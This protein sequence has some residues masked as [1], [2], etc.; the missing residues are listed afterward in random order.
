M[1]R[2]YHF[3]GPKLRDSRELPPDGEWLIE[4]LPLE[5]CQKG[6]HY[7]EHPFDALI[8]APG[9]TL[10][11][12][13]V[14][15]KIL[16]QSDKGCAEKRR[17]VARIDAK[18]L[19]LKFARDVASDVLHLW[20]APQVVKDFLA[21]GKN[22]N[23]AT[24]AAYAAYAAAAYAANAANAAANEA[25][26][27]AAATAAANAAAT[28]AAANANA[29]YAYAAATYAANAAANEAYAKHKYRGWFL[30]R[31]EAQFKELQP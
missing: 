28:Y 3:T 5:M 7:S 4:P 25:Y 11:L 2:A 10:C 26:A 15:G 23:A 1:I 18:E 27:Y 31:V 17:I 6:L 20:D 30:E 21:T 12:V 13:D 24:Y 9:F 8:Y 16:T 22:A 29:A 14:D 19:C